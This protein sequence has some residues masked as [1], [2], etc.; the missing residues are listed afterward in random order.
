MPSSTRLSLLIVFFFALAVKGLSLSD[1]RGGAVSVAAHT[2]ALEY[3]PEDEGGPVPVPVPVAVAGREASLS[4]ESLP[5]RWLSLEPLTRLGLGLG[6]A[7]AVLA[8]D[9][10][11]STLA[12]T[13]ELAAQEGGGA[14]P[15]DKAVIADDDGPAI[16]GVMVVVM[17][18]VL[19][20]A[21]EGVL[22]IVLVIV[23]VLAAK[24]MSAR[25]P[26]DELDG[27]PDI[28]RTLFTLVKVEL[29][30]TRPEE[31]DAPPPR[32]RE[33]IPLDPA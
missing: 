15:E 7:K 29:P 10:S 12:F 30:D 3:A 28:L 5:A 33:A 16:T 13:L 23:L 26:M 32:A 19:L 8:L 25:M 20:L 17:G 27:P 11:K 31:P 18:V 6:K 1:A 24:D 9:P 14:G 2:T 22:E 4:L 21:L